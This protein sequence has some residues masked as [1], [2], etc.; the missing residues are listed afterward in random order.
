M[1]AAAGPG[2]GTA[3]NEAFAPFPIMAALA[4]VPIARHM[5]LDRGP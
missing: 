2:M 4:V 3:Q 5:A 1:L